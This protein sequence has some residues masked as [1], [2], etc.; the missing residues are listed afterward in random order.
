MQKYLGYLGIAI[1][2]VAILVGA[3]FAAQSRQLRQQ[4]EEL[5]KNPQQAAQDEVKTLVESVGRIVVLPEGENPTVASITDREKLKDVPFFTKAENGDK[6]LI[7]VNARKAF[8]YRPSTSKLIEVATINLQPRADASFAPTVVIRNGTEVVGLARRFEDDLKRSLPN[9]TVTARDSA[10]KTDFA[11][12]VVVD[13]TGSRA[14]DAERLAGIVGGTVGA[15]PE[16]ETK[17]TGADFLILLGKD[18][19]SRPA[20]SPSPTPSPAGLASP[21]PSPSPSPTASPS[22]TP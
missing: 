5:K 1:A 16:G 12:T 8:L 22:P 15:L 3:S 7:Y 17:P 4:V 2:V 14:A 20:V 13:L 6:V 19:A 10:K 18:A 11:E 9:A 21:S